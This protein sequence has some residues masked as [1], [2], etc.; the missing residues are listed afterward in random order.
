MRE[1][2]VPDDAL[3]AR[4]AD[5]L[6]RLA[7]VGTGMWEGGGISVGMEEGGTGGL[8]GGTGGMTV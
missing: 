6:G 7:E 8:V 3:A 1:V 4:R 5:H 2:E